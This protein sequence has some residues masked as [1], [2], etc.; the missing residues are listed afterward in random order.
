MLKFIQCY[1]IVKQKFFYC[2]IIVIFGKLLI[3]I[4]Q[5]NNEKNYVI[6]L[7]IAFRSDVCAVNRA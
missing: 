6:M 2:K 5:K 1:Q 3:V 4:P 7:I